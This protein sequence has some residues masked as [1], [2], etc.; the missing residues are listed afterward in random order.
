MATI[1]ELLL[2]GK[3]RLAEAA[4]VPPPPPREAALLLGRVLGFSE[5]QVLARDDRPVEP[6]DAARYLE[7]IERRAGGEPVA[8]LLGEREFYG[9]VFHIDRRVL[10]PRPET[11]HL[12]EQV[13]AT[14]LPSRPRILEVGA[15]SGCIAVTLACELPAARIVATDLSAGALAV[16]RRNAVRL[17][18]TDR[19]DLIRTDLF[20]GIVPEKIDLLV[21]NPPYVD[22][23]EA[24]EMSPEVCNFEPHLALFPP[25][26]G[27][28]ETIDRLLASAAALRP[29]VRVLLEI[30]RGQLEA[31]ESSARAA[32]FDLLAAP[33]DYAGIP[34]VAVLAR[35]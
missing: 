5:A 18:A 29:G 27:G 3:A 2:R 1:G 33:A 21:S 34:R 16:A 28:L 32:G 12:I 14:P 20:T 19:V 13:L 30:G 8:Y 25:G 31:V 10:I 26:G 9:R 6:A 23:T 35:R 7:W 4:F 15:G 17:G 11:E 22:R 24:A